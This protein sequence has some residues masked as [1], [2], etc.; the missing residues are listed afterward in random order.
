MASPLATDPRRRSVTF[1]IVTIVLLV[2]L[3]VV[4]L[5][6]HTKPNREPSPLPLQGQ[7]AAPRLGLLQG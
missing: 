1:V 4:V 6:L 7:V 5:A 3:L 2:L